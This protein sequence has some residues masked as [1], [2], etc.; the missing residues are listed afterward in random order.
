ML[1]R[2]KKTAGVKSLEIGFYDTARYP[3]GTPVT[4]V[5]VW[6]EFGTRTAEGAVRTPTRPFFRNALPDIEAEGMATLKNS[7]DPATLTV[8]PRM[9]E[10]VGLQAQAT[11][12]QS[13]VTLVDPPNAPSTIAMKGS[14]NPL[15]D[16]GFMRQSVTYKVNK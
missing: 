15:I 16:T 5:A 12:Q 9:A 8:S 10:V 7:V 14:S 6:N 13:I 1:K 2:A 4:N 11:L 3:D